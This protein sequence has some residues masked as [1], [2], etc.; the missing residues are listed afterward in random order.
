ME[1]PIYLPTSSEPQ[2][3]LFHIHTNTHM[4]FSDFLIFANFDEHV[5]VSPCGVSLHFLDY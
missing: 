1:V 5:M 3:L 4:V 2:Y